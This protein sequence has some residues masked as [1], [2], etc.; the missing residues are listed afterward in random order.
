VLVVWYLTCILLLE[1]PCDL[2]DRLGTSLRVIVGVWGGILGRLLGSLG[3]L[4]WAYNCQN[5]VQRSLQDTCRLSWNWSRSRSGIAF[6]A[7]NLD[8]KR[9]L[10]L[11][12]GWNH[13]SSP[14]HIGLSVAAWLLNLY[15]TLM[16]GR[17]V[18][19]STL[20]HLASSVWICM[21]EDL[22]GSLMGVVAFPP[23]FGIR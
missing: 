13:S 22:V 8:R 15:E 9:T 10:L 5:K 17:L 19:S 6:F 11:P 23:P 12:R 7:E 1:L 4:L 14:K 21:K 16:S 18:I 2:V 3:P 20:K